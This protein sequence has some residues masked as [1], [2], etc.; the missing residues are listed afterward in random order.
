MRKLALFNSLARKK[1]AFHVS[2]RK[3]G[4]YVCGITPDAPT[5]I[6]HAFVFTFFDVLLRYIRYLGYGAIYVQ[7]VTDID[8]D[9]L[10]RAQGKN[11]KKFGQKHTKEFLK[12]MKWLN[13]MAPNVYPKATGHI[14]DMISIIQ[15]L[16]DIGVAYE[17]NKSVYF[18]IAK[19]KDYGKLSGLSKKAMLKI[20]NER[21][22][23][24]DD[25][26]KKDPLDFVLWQAKKKG[27]PSWASPWGK[28]R[29]GWHIECSAMAMKYLGKTLDIQGGGNDLM[30]P[31]HESSIAQSENATGKLCARFWLHAGM[32]RYKK[33]KMAKSLGNV[34]LIKDM[35]KKYSASTFRI[36]LLSHHYRSSW[37]FFEK[38]VAK[39]NTI[40]NLFKRAGHIQS[41]GNTPFFVAARERRFYGAMNN[42][43]DTP[44]A[45]K[46]LE[47]LAKE[48]VKVHQKK[49]VVQAKAFLTTA[50]NILGLAIQ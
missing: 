5:H 6:G 18:S 42:D 11:W 26:N 16:L 27:E 28:G 50:F 48:I 20:A 8:D 46:V 39:A 19:D 49:N 31:H 37:E 24:P 33:A 25:P 17:K 43:M 22:N 14:V 40:N 2:G 4:I 1:E 41:K 38:N 47:G 35:R 12:D 45:L 7:N 44:Q 32:V 30:F 3:A 10:R 36:F 23:Y 21:G 9:I 34:V 29:P 13:N 15:K